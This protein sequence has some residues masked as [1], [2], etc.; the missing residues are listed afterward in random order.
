MLIITIIILLD[1]HILV[2][3]IDV[4][5]GNVGGNWDDVGEGEGGNTSDWGGWDLLFGIFLFFVVISFFSFFLFFF[6]K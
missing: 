3:K 4:C 2:Y 1:R 6:S 5:R